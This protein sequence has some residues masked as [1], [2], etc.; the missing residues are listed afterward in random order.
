MDV[1]MKAKSIMYAIDHKAYPIPSYMEKRVQKAIEEELL[2]IER[3]EEKKDG[4]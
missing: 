2:K 1:T 3:K 4:Q